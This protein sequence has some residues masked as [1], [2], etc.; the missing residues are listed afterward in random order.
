MLDTSDRGSPRSNHRPFSIPVGVATEIRHQTLIAARIKVIGRF[1]LVMILP[2][3]HATLHQDAALKKIFFSV[4]FH[5]INRSH[6]KERQ[7]QSFRWRE[8]FFV[9]VSHAAKNKAVCT[10][11][12]QRSLT[13][14]RQVCEI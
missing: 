10:N 14:R 5:E 11:A 6:K 2:I 3:A 12:V 7:P 13:P 4:N 1:T 9:L 8:I